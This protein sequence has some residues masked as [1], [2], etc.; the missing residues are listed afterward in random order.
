MGHTKDYS[1][2]IAAEIDAEVRS[3]I[4]LAH[5]EAWE[6]LVEYRDVWTASCSS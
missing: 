4:E 2:A 6:I 5:D 3:L 1:D